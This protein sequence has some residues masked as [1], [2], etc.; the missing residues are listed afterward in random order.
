MS[1]GGNEMNLD[2]SVKKKKMN[3]SEEYLAGIC[4]V[5]YL[6][7]DTMAASFML[8]STGKKCLDPIKILK[9]YLIEQTFL[10]S[11]VLSNLK[12]KIPNE[13]QHCILGHMKKYFLFKFE[14]KD[15]IDGVIFC[16]KLLNRKYQNIIIENSI[17]EK[18]FFFHSEGKIS[19]KKETM[20]RRVSSIF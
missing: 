7:S 11:N 2:L 9:P 16:C 14:S 6:F 1:W 12:E 18:D 15:F 5:L 19:E 20:E 13:N 17:Q 10:D 4:S 3:T 8:I